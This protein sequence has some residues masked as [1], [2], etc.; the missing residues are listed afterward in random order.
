MAASR[1]A[2]V[3]EFLTAT[4]PFSRIM[5]HPKYVKGISALFALAL[6]VLAS[7]S[8]LNDDDPFFALKKNFQ[9]FG[10]L[11]EQL[12][13]EYVDP[14]NPETLMRDGI[15][16]MLK[17]L[18]PYTTFYDEADHADIEIMTRGNYG[19]VGLNIGIQNGRTMVIS[20][21]ENAS[22]YTQGVR[23]GDIITHIEDLS[24]EGF[25]IKDLQSLLRGEPGTT[26][27]IT[28][29]REGAPEPLD[30][31]LTR[32]QVQLKNVT[33][34]RLI[35]ADSLPGVAY[36][37]LE[38]FARGAAK[39]V[40]EALIQLE[41]EQA[42]NAIVLD[43]RDNPGGLLN[44]AVSLTELFVPQNETIVFT[45]GRNPA[46]EQSYRSKV[47]PRFPDIPLIVLVNHISA[48]ASEIVA[49]AIQ[50]LDRGLIVGE[51]TFGKG[52]VQIVKPLPYNTA[53]KI[54]TSRY[55]IPSGRSIQ[56]IDYKTHDGNF[57][58]I[59]DSLRKTFQTKN[60]R[61]VLDGRGIEPDLEVSMGA[62]SEFEQALRRRAAIFLYANHFAAT[63]PEVAP[64]F[65]V[66][67]EIYDA[68]AVWL[69]TQD[70]T[71]RTNSE[72]IAEELADQLLANGYDDT[73][74][75][76]AVLKQAI[77]EE[78][79][80]DFDRY[81]TSIKEKLRAEILARY[82]G[83]TAQIEA[84]IPND[85]Q[86]MAGLNLIKEPATYQGHLSVK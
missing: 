56:A 81:Q 10:S 23:A 52:L 5:K 73:S 70:F 42:L 29:Y 9:I 27:A 18:D 66:T 15:D 86:L 67:D 46:T 85:Q 37:K 50:D 21:V 48:S 55:F 74:D 68:F 79:E 62:N 51:T 20:P 32:E 80:E 39:D 33:F 78:K 30:F 11:Y 77:A 69:D 31:V 1:A 22:G 7:F 58:S 6:L 63:N 82:Y 35:G 47:P 59:P 83:E 12:V 61:T 60:G 64:D 43:L 4:N 24:T 54:T 38:R 3:W 71:Y 26:V 65:K 2:R 16:A 49:G 14:L 8:F 76:M 44:E 57:N 40:K 75:E 45:R 72:R 41:A 19:G 13:S 36:V 17:N 25:T 84:F 28:I 34:S 53:I